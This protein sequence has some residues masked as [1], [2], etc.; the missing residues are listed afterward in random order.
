MLF[1]DCKQQNKIIASLFHIQVVVLFLFKV[2][3]RIV[4]GSVFD[5]FK[6]KYGETLVTGKSKALF[7]TESKLILLRDFL[8]VS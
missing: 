5:E 2:I 4:D 6:A 1:K 3:A 8:F 7:I